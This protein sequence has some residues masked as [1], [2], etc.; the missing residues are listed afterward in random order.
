MIILINLLLEFLEKDLLWGDYTTMNFGFQNNN[1]RGSSIFYVN[2]IT[3]DGAE[4]K[5]MPKFANP[6]FASF[7]LLPPLEKGVPASHKECIKW[8]DSVVI[9]VKNNHDEWNNERACGL[10]GCKVAD[11]SFGTMTFGPS[12]SDPASF[13]IL[14]P[15]GLFRSSEQCVRSGDKFVIA[16]NE[17]TSGA[18]HGVDTKECGN[19]GC[20]VGTLH[21]NKLYFEDG[22]HSLM[23]NFN[24]I[25]RSRALKWD[26]HV[27]INSWFEPTGDVLGREIL[28]TDNQDD[29]TPLK[30]DYKSNNPVRTSFRLLQPRAF[31]GATEDCI[32]WN[33]S[34]VLKLNNDVT[35]S[36]CGNKYGCRLASFDWNLY[37]M[38]F[39]KQEEAF[40]IRSINGIQRFGCIR[41]GEQIYFEAE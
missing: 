25:K 4:M 6:K 31:D 7:Q 14:P 8:T 11:A 27:V 20:R 9:S 28:Y 38:T 37:T 2:S 33:D 22:R 5:I 30:W 39:S 41:S 24:H 19:H 29:N 10:H 17:P 35:E 23:F 18:D 32:S 1:L 12:G 3:D 13:T 36:G 40:K 15:F 21:E 26:D 16:V 34:V